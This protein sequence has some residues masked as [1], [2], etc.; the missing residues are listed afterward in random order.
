MAVKLLIDAA[1]SYVG[2]K[3]RHRGR[4][5]FGIDCIGLVVKSMEAAGIQMRDRLDYGREPWKDGLEHEMR[6]HFGEPVLDLKAGDV[7]TMRGIGQLGAGHV[8]I[9]AEKNGY[10]TL[11]HSYNA[12][13]N[14]RVTEHR[15]DEVWENRISEIFR[16]FK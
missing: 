1:R 5:K 7:I 2:V 12:D 4:S 9:V 14:S 16:P 15:I 11:I 10:L 6:A 8:G 3:W 13:A